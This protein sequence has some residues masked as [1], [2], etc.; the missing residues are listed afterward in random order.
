MN[1]QE[2]LWGDVPGYIEHPVHCMLAT[3]LL[4]GVLQQASRVA[5]EAE[6]LPGPM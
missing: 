3:V 1:F 4:D 6:E 5:F 2:N